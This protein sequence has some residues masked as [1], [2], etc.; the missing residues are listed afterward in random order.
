LA[1]LALVDGVVVAVDMT[2]FSLL[3]IFSST[4]LAEKLKNNKKKLLFLIRYQMQYNNYNPT[5]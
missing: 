5:R 2:L 4:L 1:A 3:N